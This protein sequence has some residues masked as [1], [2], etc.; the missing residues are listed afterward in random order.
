MI[1]KYVFIIRPPKL[2]ELETTNPYEALLDIVSSHIYVNEEAI[3]HFSNPIPVLGIDVKAPNGN[4][5]TLIPQATI[6]L[7]PQF[8][9]KTQH[10]Y[11]FNDLITGFL[12]SIGKICNNGY[13][14]FFK[15]SSEDN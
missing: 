14:A 15:I 7:A 5:I 11:I 12:M 4:I 13:I 2:K 8:S 1:D 10:V 3:P 9:V 6:H